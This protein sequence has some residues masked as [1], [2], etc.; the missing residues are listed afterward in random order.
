MSKY[1]PTFQGEVKDSKITVTK[2]KRMWRDWIAKLSGKK[3]E[4]RVKEWKD[5]RS[6]RQNN[7]MWAWLAILEQE[8][9]QP[10]DDI[11]DYFKAKF[12]TRTIVIKGKE[13]KVVGS[14]ASLKSDGFTEYLGQFRAESATFFKVDL[15][16]PYEY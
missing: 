10:K 7:L 14:T 6:E 1:T 12:L 2:A 5:S 16:D 11:H 9:G 15:P 4:I 13:F 3:I 8:T